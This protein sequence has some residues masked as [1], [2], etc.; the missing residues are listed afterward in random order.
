MR[1]LRLSERTA[2]AVLEAVRDLIDGGAGAGTIKL[3]AGAPPA[4]PDDPV[5]GQVLLATFT[6]SDPSAGPAS[7]GELVFSPIADAEFAAASGRAAWAR[8]EDS[9]G[10]RI[11]DADAGPEGSGAALEID[12]A[13]I[14]IGQPVR[15]TNARLALFKEA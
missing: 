15:V 5:N 13:D 10:R 11:A 1:K 8:I 7:G 4:A 9:G 3:Y 6:F 14:T 12:R 2:G